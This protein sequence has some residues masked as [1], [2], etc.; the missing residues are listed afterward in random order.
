MV[1][2]EKIDDSVEIV[3][4]VDIDDNEVGSAPRSEVRKKNLIHRCSYIFLFNSEFKLYVHKSKK[5][6]IFHFFISLII[7]LS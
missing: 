3:Q 2:V 7:S 6:N 5:N 1:E 4:V